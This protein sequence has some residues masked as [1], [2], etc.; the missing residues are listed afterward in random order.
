M[1][2]LWVL[3]NQR[4]QFPFPFLL[5]AIHAGS[6]LA[7]TCMLI[8]NGRFSLSPISKAQHIK[9]SAFSLLYTINIA[10]SNLSL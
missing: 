1:S 2:S 6:S 7:G 8:V 10:I 5:T 3:A 4:E 9:L